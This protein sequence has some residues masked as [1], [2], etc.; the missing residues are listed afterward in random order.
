MYVKEGGGHTATKENYHVAA[1]IAHSSANYSE[2]K[3]AMESLL[4]S[5]LLNDFIFRAA[6]CPPFASGRTAAVLAGNITVGYVGEVSPET[7]ANLSIKVPVGAFEI[8]V[9]VLPK[10]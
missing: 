4:G 1:A 10:N 9:S 2:I 8:D 7:L 3:S 6:E 5:G